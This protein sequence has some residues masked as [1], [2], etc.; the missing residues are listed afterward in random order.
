MLRD[1]ELATLTPAIRAER[2]IRASAGALIVRVG[3]SLAEQLG[4]MAGDVIVMINRREVS[5]AQDA[6]RLI[7]AFGG[8]SVIEMVFERQGRTEFIIR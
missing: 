2:N 1:L 7:D 5:S 8:R 3:E 4:V 6:A